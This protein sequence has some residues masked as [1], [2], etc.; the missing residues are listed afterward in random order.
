MRQWMCCLSWLSL[1]TCE[2]SLPFH[3]SY[4]LSFGWIILG[5]FKKWRCVTVVVVHPFTEEI[6]YVKSSE[7][8]KVAHLNDKQYTVSAEHSCGFFFPQ[9]SKPPSKVCM[10]PNKV[11]ICWQSSQSSVGLLLEPHSCCG[12]HTKVPSDSSWS[13]VNPG[14]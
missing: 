5:R 9:L 13:C 8:Q 3:I 1:F 6:S 4:L 10:G 12:N 11:L 2:V 7:T 14:L